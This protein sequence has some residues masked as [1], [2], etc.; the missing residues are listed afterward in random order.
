M[1]FF[2][3]RDKLNDRRN[4]A[5]TKTMT[6]KI[7]Y[8]TQTIFTIRHFVFQSIELNTRM[9]NNRKQKIF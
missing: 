3:F 8:L 1:L 7:N 4:D 2:C 9:N 6:A 5:K